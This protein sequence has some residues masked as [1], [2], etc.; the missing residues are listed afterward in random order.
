MFVLGLRAAGF[1]EHR[2]VRDGVRLVVDRLLPSGGANYGNTIVLGQPLAPH[3]QPSGLA[4]LALAG[5]PIAD[6]RIGKSVEY[7][8]GAINAETAAPSLAMAILGLTAHGQGREEHADWIAAS[9]NRPRR[10]P[11]AVFEQSLLLLAAA[12]ADSIAELSGMPAEIP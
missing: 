12:P 8:A 10:S 5:E 4:L 3:I 1:G 2:C 7:V 6:A 11:L 9:L